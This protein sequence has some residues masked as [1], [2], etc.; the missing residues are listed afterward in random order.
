MLTK[1]CCKISY[2][3]L[4]LA[5]A[6]VFVL[7]GIS[8]SMVNAL[9]SAEVAINQERLDV[10]M[11]LLV[12]LKTH[13]SFQMRIVLSQSQKQRDAVMSILVQLNGK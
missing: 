1:V 8:L 6:F 2:I 4:I 3:Q 12:V 13:L 7:D 9:K 11:K 10:F 5:V